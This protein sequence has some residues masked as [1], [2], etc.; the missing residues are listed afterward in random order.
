MTK[1]SSAALQLPGKTLQLIF[2]YALSVPITL[3]ISKLACPIL[4]RES[5]LL[6]KR[7]AY[8][9][10]HPVVVMELLLSLVLIRRIITIQNHAKALVVHG[11]RQLGFNTVITSLNK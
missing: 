9:I 2:P 8:W 3:R 11:L 7:S 5:F 6:F 4:R 1:G 10:A